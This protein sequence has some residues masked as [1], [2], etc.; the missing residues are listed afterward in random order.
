MNFKD[1]ALAF[2]Q[3]E[4]TS[5]RLIITE[6]LAALF[7]DAS[8]SEASVIAYMSLGELY[9]PYKT[10]QFNMA[11]K[12]VVPVVARLCDLDE[13]EVKRLVQES[14]DL[15]TI[16]AQ[17]KK[18][19]GEVSAVL[20]VYTTLCD[21]AL[22]SGTGSQ[23][24][25]AQALYELLERVS[26]LEGKYIV[27]M[28][29]GKLR[30]GFSDMTL[31]DALS[32]MLAGNK[33]Q[34]S[35]VENAYNTCADIGRIAAMAKSGGVEALGKMHIVVGIPIRPSAAERLP[36]AH[37]IFNKLG[38]CIAQPKLD[39]FRLQIHL[40]KKENTIHFFSRNLLD[41][42]AMFPDLVEALQQLPVETLICEG[43]AISWDANTGIFLPFQETVKRK[44]KHDVEKTAQEFPLKLFL[45]D[46]L[47]LDGVEYLS[48]THEERRT[49]LVGLFS[50][51]ESDLVQV[52]DE[53]IITQPQQL[54]DYF[55][56]S[57]ERGLEGLVVKRPDALYQPGKRNF[58]WI[59]LKRHNVG[60]LE[61]TI[62][63]VIVGY[64][65]GKG[66]RASFGIGALLVAVY[67]KDKDRYETVAK[68]G[69]GVTDAGWKELKERCDQNRVEQQPHNVICAKELYPDVWVD[70][71]IICAIRADEITISP[72][73]AAG[74]T[75]DALGYALRFPRMVGYRDDK[76]ILDVTTVDEIKQ[77][78]AIQYKQG[79]STAH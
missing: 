19:E 28:I 5:S 79:E 32:W 72:M 70:P 33:S 8:A 41:M 29:L 75:S 34:R 57:I 78:Y 20:Q 64:Y 7:S 66:K 53:K 55:L 2:N 11:E 38:P 24:K 13:Q 69:T 47:Y 43:E 74:K 35:L 52:I 65:N 76:G 14:G 67:N 56:Q 71:S 40:N 3:I 50:H 17:H 6:K 49:A 44:R 15:G 23:E 16:V 46:L 9:P 54:H 42:S 31:I 73:H 37:D 45:F 58:N 61:D 36:S 68:I 21:I 18:S 48:K 12:T 63:A 62:D 10:L 30:L 22:I 1:L 26:A 39:G 25:K 27:R 59:K 51:A 4:E 60:E 77:L